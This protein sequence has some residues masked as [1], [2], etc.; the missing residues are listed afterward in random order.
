MKST[1]RAFFYL[2]LTG[3]GL[4]GIGLYLLFFGGE[5]AQQANGMLLVA[6]TLGLGGLMI[7]PYPV[8]KAVQWMHEK[9]S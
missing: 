3:L 9:D 4:I 6:V 2:H 5:T 1:L 8:V 7:S